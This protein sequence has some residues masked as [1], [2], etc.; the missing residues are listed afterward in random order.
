MIFVPALMALYGKF[1]RKI[2]HF[3]RYSKKELEEKCKSAGFTIVISRYFDF[4]GIVPWFVKYKILRSD[5]LSSGAVKLYDW[6]V[7]PFVKRF[8]SVV[9]VPLGKN[10]VMVVRKD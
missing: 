9:K 7:I 1:D 2:G 3:R 6:L 8:E 4:A 5:S 10:V